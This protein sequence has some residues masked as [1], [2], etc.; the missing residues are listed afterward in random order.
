MVLICKPL[1]WTKRLL[2]QPV[3]SYFAHIA[4]VWIIRGATKCASIRAGH[5]AGGLSGWMYRYFSANHQLAPIGICESLK[6]GCRFRFFLCICPVLNFSFQ[7]ILHGA[8]YG[9][10]TRILSLGSS[11]TTIILSPRKKYYWLLSSS[12]SWAETSYC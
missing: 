8:G 3:P 1:S 10:R 12:V 2:W 11:C 5:P 7:I 9:N 4:N 6:F